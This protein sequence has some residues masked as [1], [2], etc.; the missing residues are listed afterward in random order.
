MLRMTSYF[1]ALLFGIL[2]HT[3]CEQK[4]IRDQAIESVIEETEEKLESTDESNETANK[5]QEPHAYGGWFCPD[6]FGGFP[7]VDIQELSLVP[8]VKDRLP[9]QEETRDGRSLIFVDESEYPDAHPLKMDLPQVATIYSPHNELNELIIVIQALVIGSDT[10]VGYRFPNG[11]NGSAWYGEVTFLSDKEV[12]AMGARPHVY[13][14]L[15]IKASKEAVWNAIIKTSYAKKLGSQFNQREFFNSKWTPDSRAHLEKYADDLRAK[16]MV[17]DVWG[18]IYMHI[19]YDQ[20]GFHHAEK[21][22][23]SGNEDNMTA[24]LHMVAGPY[25][26][27]VFSQKQLWKTWMDEVKVMA[28]LGE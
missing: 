14:K 10:I 25:P 27:D 7:P 13:E 2:L 11:G 1:S 21:L 17:A 4:V 18:N 3:S 15:E 28:E 26:K 8:V 19:D 6:N 23:I 5:Y 16:G 12:K 22:L 20:S 9:T 24:E